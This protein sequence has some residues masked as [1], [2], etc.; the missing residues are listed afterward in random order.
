MILHIQLLLLFVS[1]SSCVELEAD[2]CLN[3]E[4]ETQCCYDT[5]CP[6][7]GDGSFLP[8]DLSGKC[9]DLLQSLILSWSGCAGEGC[10]SEW[11]QCFLGYSF[12]RDCGQPR[13]WSQEGKKCVQPWE[14]EECGVTTTTTAS[15]TKRNTCTKHTSCQ[16]DGYYEEGECQAEFCQCWQGWGW[17][18]AC[19]E[20]LKFDQNLPGCRWEADVPS[21]Q[22]TTTSAS[23]STTSTTTSSTTTTTSTTTSST[24]TG[25]LCDQ[26]CSG[27]DDDYVATDCCSEN[28]CF[29]SEVNN[30]PL[31]KCKPGEGFCSNLSECVQESVV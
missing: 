3:G 25:S 17:V 7:V 28:F 26:L 19:M 20:P 27:F 24:T 30:N 4:H 18:M 11:C 29:C 9:E 16:E 21:C 15:T 1:A 14:V 23:T 22:T 12:Y 13:V 8:S 2:M 6:E 5:Y 10:C 31:L